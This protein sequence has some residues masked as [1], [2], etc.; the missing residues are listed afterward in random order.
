[1]PARHVRWGLCAGLVLCG[2]SMQM[3]AQP[4]AAVPTAWRTD[5]AAQ[6]LGT[7]SGEIQNAN[8]ARAENDAHCVGPCRAP[9]RAEPTAVNVPVDWLGSRLG[10]KR[11]SSPVAASDDQSENHRITVG[12]IVGALAGA[13]ATGIVVN[14]CKY[15]AQSADGPPCEVG[16]LIVGI[17]A[18]VG[19]GAIGGLI[20]GVTG[21]RGRS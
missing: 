7:K 8:F 16:Y 12:V 21:R 6:D 2:Q 3:W 15:T 9:H 5:G 20:A 14:H 19:G 11:L 13:V 1:M 4:N 17:P 18:I 10:Y